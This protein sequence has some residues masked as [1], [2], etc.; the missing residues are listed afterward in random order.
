MEEESD[1]GGRVCQAR[2]L[3]RGWGLTGGGGAWGQRESDQGEEP[4]CQGPPWDLKG[5]VICWFVSCFS[6]MRWEEGHLPFW[7]WGVIV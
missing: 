7:T 6:P 3:I 5:L 4:S 2:S 1:K